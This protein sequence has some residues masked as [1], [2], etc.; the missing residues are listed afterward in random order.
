MIVI[1]R[2]QGSHMKCEDPACGCPCHGR[3]RPAAARSTKSRPASRKKDQPTRPQRTVLSENQ[4]EVIR[5]RYMEGA[6]THELAAEYHC[7]LVKIREALGSLTRVQRRVFSESD[8]VIIRDLYSDGASIKELAKKFGCAEYKIS[9]VV[10]DLVRRSKRLTPDEIEHI[11]A[12]KA[13]GETIASMCRRL[14]KDRWTIYG[15]LGKKRQPREAPVVECGSTFTRDGVTYSCEVKCRP[16][17]TVPHGS[18]W[19]ESETGER[20]RIQWQ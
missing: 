11:R 16:H 15:A 2:C 12:S 14:G 19:V 10:K 20:V 5:N 4:Q 17:P 1:E 6:T 13:S 7:S 9:V 3:E 18:E 8:Q